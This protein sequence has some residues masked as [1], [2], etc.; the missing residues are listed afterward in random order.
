MYPSTN[1]R[2]RSS[3]INETN[4]ET[5]FQR[6]ALNTL[7]STVSQQEVEIKR[8]NECLEVRNKRIMNLEAQVGHASD[9]FADR[10]NTTTRPPEHELKALAEKVDSI[11]L[12]LEK[13]QTSQPSNNIVINSCR[14]ENPS[15]ML[16]S[17]TQTDVSDL[18]T[19]NDTF[20]ESLI[21]EKC[22]KT[23]KSQGDLQVHLRDEH[24]EQNAL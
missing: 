17:S 19:S 5:E 18:N 23:Y 15:S 4:P 11:V 1:T 22:N 24:T 21:C 16:H 8:L 2:Q 12:K 6:T 14:S 9:L 3:N 13:L 7:R 10:N 20:S